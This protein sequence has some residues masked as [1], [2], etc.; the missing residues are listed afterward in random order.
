[1]RS[2]RHALLTALFVG[3]TAAQAATPTLIWYPGDFEI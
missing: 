2:F 1:M 3:S